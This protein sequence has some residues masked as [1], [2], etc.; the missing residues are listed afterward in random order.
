MATV[1][2]RGYAGIGTSGPENTQTHIG[3]PD[4]A[5]AD[6]ERY[7][8]KSKGI[9]IKHRSAKKKTSIKNPII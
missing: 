7:P 6:L 8:N 1:A 4:I 2:G 3:R 9:K 5:G